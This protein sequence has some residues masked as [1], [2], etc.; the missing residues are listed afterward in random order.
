[1]QFSNYLPSLPP[2]ALRI[3]HES[4]REALVCAV[5]PVVRGLF[6]WPT[7]LRAIKGVAF[8]CF[9]SQTQSVWICAC[10]GV[11]EGTAPSDDQ[12]RSRMFGDTCGCTFAFSGVKPLCNCFVRP[13]ENS[14]NGHV[15]SAV[16]L[17]PHGFPV[18]VNHI[19]PTRS[20]LI[21]W[22]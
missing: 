8:F 22:G 21:S 1:M 14:S 3:A 6:C 16:E 18:F 2:E 7:V 13:I 5:W 4:L 15:C 20:S 11:L 12:I 10:P 17:S 9:T 19:S